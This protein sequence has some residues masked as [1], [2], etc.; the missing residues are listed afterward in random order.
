MMSCCRFYFKEKEDAN[1]GLVSTVDGNSK[2]HEQ[3]RVSLRT[4]I[5]ISQHPQN[6]QLADPSQGMKNSEISERK[7]HTST[8]DIPTPT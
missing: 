8:P 1:R 4:G 2:R 7:R 5:E 6:E 3:A